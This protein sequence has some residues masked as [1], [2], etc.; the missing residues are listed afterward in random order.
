MEI[1]QT[2]RLWQRKRYRFS[3]TELAELSSLPE[4]ELRQWV[5]QG[6]LVPIDPEAAQ[7]VFGVDHRIT[8]RMARQLRKDIAR[9]PDGLSL[10]VTLL[11]RVQALEAEVRE[12][13]AI[14]P[15]LP[16]EAGSDSF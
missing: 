13:R 4:A 15:P 8:V 6:V 5:D 16:R 3:L 12:L 14:A 2:T 10:V 7:W 1:E 9:E 11:D